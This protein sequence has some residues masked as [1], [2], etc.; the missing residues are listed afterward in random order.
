MIFKLLAVLCC[1]RNFIS[2]RYVDRYLNATN[3]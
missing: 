1:N 2:K 3:K